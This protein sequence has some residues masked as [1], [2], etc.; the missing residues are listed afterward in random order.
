MK[1]IAIIPARYG[2]KR[3]PGKPLIQI[4]K[5]PLIQITYESVLNSN[6]FDLIFVATESK[7]IKKTVIDFGG[8][9]LLTSSKHLNGTERCAELINKLKNKVDEQDLVINIQCDEPFIQKKHLK[10][11]I[12]LLVGAT[13]IGTLISPI[14]KF[15]IRNKSIVKVSVK[16]N[17]AVNFSR[18]TKTFSKKTKLYKHIGIYG[19]QIKVLRD[20]SKLKTT[21]RELIESLEQLRWI[22]YDYKISCAFT[23]DS[24]KSIN[25][26]TDLKKL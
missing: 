2:S 13:Q 25:T 1:I 26:I 16:N 4:N 17:T 12:D 7:E 23:K 14:K 10:K 15:E 19:Y 21:D 6:L 9:C 8:N 20:L 11:I 24:I 3:L 5:K 22:S 18:D